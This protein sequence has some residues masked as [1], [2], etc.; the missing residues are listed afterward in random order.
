LAT[1]ERRSVAIKDEKRI[2]ADIEKRLDQLLRTGRALTR[3]QWPKGPLLLFKIDRRGD[4][5][6]MTHNCQTRAFA[7]D[8]QAHAIPLDGRPFR[9]FRESEWQS[10]E[11]G[12]GI[13]LLIEP[14][15][16]A[17]WTLDAL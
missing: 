12:Y 11:R 1:G 13:L 4:T 9:H 2:R 15:E 8:A 5:Y 14:D 3:S 6:P 17:N 16:P 7:V 10:I